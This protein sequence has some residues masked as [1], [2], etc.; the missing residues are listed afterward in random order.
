[1][2]SGFIFTVISQ[3]MKCSKNPV[4]LKYI[5]FVLKSCLKTTVL[6]LN[7]SSLGD[8]KIFFEFA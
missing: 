8:G 2:K 7:L 3:C 6:L 4:V 1:M 5:Y